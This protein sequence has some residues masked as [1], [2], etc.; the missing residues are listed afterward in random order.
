VFDVALAF[1]VMETILQKFPRRTV[2]WTH[3]FCEEKCSLGFL[4]TFA[5]DSYSNRVP[6]IA[7]ASMVM[8]DVGTLL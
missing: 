5:W 4:V 3:I 7:A 8:D 1:D 6:H 2:S